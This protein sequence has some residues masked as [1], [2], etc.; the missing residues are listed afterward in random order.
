[1]KKFLLYFTLIISMHC[2]VGQ[3]ILTG[4][5]TNV[6]DGDTFTLLQA[7]GKKTKIRIVGIDAPE[8]KQ[9]FGIVSRDYARSLLDVKKVTVYLEPGE[10]YGRKLGVVITSDGVN[11][12]YLMVANGYA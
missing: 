12:N 11:F 9:D 6:Y 7:N 2:M 5:A 8:A 4:T 3:G 1:M 10:T